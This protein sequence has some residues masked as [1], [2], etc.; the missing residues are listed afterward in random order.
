MKS[1]AV[2][3]MQKDEADLLQ[4]FA[5]YYSLLFGSENLYIF[6][7]GSNERIQRILHNLEKDGCNII[8]GYNEQND[9]EK[10][11]LIFTEYFKKYQDKYDVFL[12]LDCDEFIGVE[13]EDGFSCNK[14]EIMQ[15]LNTVAPNNAYQIRSIYRNHPIYLDMFHNY[16]GHKKFFFGKGEIR[17]LSVGYHNFTYPKR[18]INSQLI[19]F[20]FHHKPFPTLIEHARN[21]MRSRITFNDAKQLEFYKGAG[22]HLIKYLLMPSEREYHNYIDSLEWVFDNSLLLKFQKNQMTLPFNMKTLHH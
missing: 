1:V 3:M 2:F 19:Y 8:M 10:K 16:Q 13:T 17:D 21:K 4:L 14:H 9:F 7:N 5:Q 15:E 18:L 6:D 11:G 12:P 22:N 20:E